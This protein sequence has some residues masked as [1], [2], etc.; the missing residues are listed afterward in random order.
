MKKILL[1]NSLI[2]FY[3]KNK[4][5][6]SRSDFQVFT[7]LTVMEALQVHRKERVDLIV[8]DLNMPEMG[9][10]KLCS[11][12][13]TDKEFKNVSILL[14]CCD[15]PEELK[16]VAQSAANAWVTKPINNGE[17]L[18]KI[19]Q[20][21]A[22]PVRKD[23]RV[24]LK[25]KVEGDQESTPFFCTS[26]NIST[27]GILIETGR[28]LNLGDR[29]TCTFFLPG[30]RQIVA[31]GEAVRSGAAADGCYHYGIRFIDLSPEYRKEIERFVAS[32]I[33]AG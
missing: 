3:E 32:L 6:L 24:L 22:V 5:L 21:L 13:R 7:A 19:G 1:V 2:V 16:M 29:L 31:G 18:E 33:Q 25:A 11:L 12:I 10:D 28:V 9:G 23:Y 30:A 17:F 8:A 20:L 14:T 4:G 26:Y 27:S 15:T